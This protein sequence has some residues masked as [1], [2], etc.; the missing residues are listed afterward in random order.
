MERRYLTTGAEIRAAKDEGFDFT[1]LASRTGVEY[2]MFE[3]EDSIWV[4]EI[5]SNAFDDVLDN[6]VRTLI[7]HQ[8]SL[9]LG[10]TKSGTAKIW[11][12]KDGLR[13]AWKN[14]ET[15]YA[16][17]IAV[18]I[19]RGDVDQSSFGFR[20]SWNNNKWEET[21]LP[22]GRRKYKRTILK[23]DELFDTSPVTFPANPNTTV[24]A[25]DIKTAYE[26][27]QEYRKQQH[28]PEDIFDE[29]EILKRQTALNERLAGL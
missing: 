12:D 27:Y 14:P 29:L 15:S 25:R 19:N 4:E 13:Y 3:D 22:D 9:I 23:F 2:V 16:S 24:G 17:D 10:R 6:D 11:T 20:T 28:P 7:N 1:G 8:S 18:S 21:P 26:E 5:A